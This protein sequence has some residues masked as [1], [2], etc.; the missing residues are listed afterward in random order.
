MFDRFCLITSQVDAEIKPAL[1]DG[2][3]TLLHGLELS[4]ADKR[5]SLLLNSVAGFYPTRRRFCRW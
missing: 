4:A 1:D 3:K 5:G 2:L